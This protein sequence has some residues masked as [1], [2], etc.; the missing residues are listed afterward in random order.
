M[1]QLFTSTSACMISTSTDQHY[2][3]ESTALAVDSNC[4][5]GRES[6][7]T[8]TILIPLLL[9]GFCCTA[10]FFLQ[11]VRTLIK[12]HAVFFKN[13]TSAELEFAQQ[14]TV[15]HYTLNNHQPM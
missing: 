13:S 4:L 15:I 1:S 2:K 12:Y 6:F 14:G 10:Q 8:S 9:A 5:L 3:T 11:W 7:F